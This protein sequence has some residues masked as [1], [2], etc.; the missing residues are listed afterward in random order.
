LLTA[1]V[2]SAFAA[3]GAAS[4]GSRVAQWLDPATGAALAPRA[5]FDDL[6]ATRVVLLGEVH[7][8]RAHHRWQHYMLSVL[9]SRNTN[10]IIGL[11]MLP[12]RV[13]PTLDAWER[14]QAR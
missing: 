6:A 7:D 14:W 13:Q 3:D 9:H 10:M 12:R 1:T 5:L 8:N 11:E 2:N 4:C